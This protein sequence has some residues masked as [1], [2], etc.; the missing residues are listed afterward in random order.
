MKTLLFTLVTLFFSSTALATGGGGGGNPGPA[1]G[2]NISASH[3]FDA[4]A[5]RIK[6]SATMKKERRCPV[7]GVNQID[8]LNYNNFYG[9]KPK[10]ETLSMI[11]KRKN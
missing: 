2:V 11:Q 9:N 5:K 4:N 7:T 8:L 10:N 1:A 3:C 6:G